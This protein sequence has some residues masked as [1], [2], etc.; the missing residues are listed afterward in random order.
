M[1]AFLAVLFIL[2]TPG[3][4]LTIPPK[5]SKIIVAA[6]IHGIIFAIIYHFT[7]KTVWKWTRKYEGFAD[8]TPLKSRIPVQGFENPPKE[9]KKI[10][11]SLGF[12]LTSK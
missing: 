3:V 6:V 10:A 9:L 4:L 8:A 1:S 7:N 11:E 2:L 5:G 12:N